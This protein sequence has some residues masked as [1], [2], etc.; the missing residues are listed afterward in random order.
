[1]TKEGVGKN[2]I[3]K[4][5]LKIPAGAGTLAGAVLMLISVVL[6]FMAN[7]KVPFMMDDLWYSTNI[8]DGSPLTGISDII[9]SQKWHYVSWGGRVFTHGFLQLVLMSGE[10]CAD[11]INVICTVIVSVE[12]YLIS[13]LVSGDDHGKKPV[14]FFIMYG[15]LISLCPDFKMSMLWE[16]GCANYVYSTVWILAFYLIYIRVLAGKKDLPLSTVFIIPLSL[17]TGWSTENMG[18][19]AF[20]TALFITVYVIIKKSASLKT[21]IM[22]AEGVVF[23]LVGSVLCIL[24]PGNYVR[25]DVGNAEISEGA[26]ERFL[27]MLKGAGQYLFPALLLLAACFVLYRSVKD[28]LPPIGICMMIFASVM[29]FGAF[30]LSPH[31]PARAAFG[32]C[33]LLEICAGGLLNSLPLEKAKKL[34]T[35]S[36]LLLTASVVVIFKVIA[37]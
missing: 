10:L 37:E 25:K 1:M 23:S 27:Q 15:M 20:V 4:E 33:V 13:L 18:P 29:S 3:S 31:Y 6:L 14:I 19:A 32:T 7:I 8:S 28:A 2:N 24:A 17:I 12:M 21:K 16:A 9:E 30:V 11:V 22:M 5:A 36:L 34:E 35:V 26:F